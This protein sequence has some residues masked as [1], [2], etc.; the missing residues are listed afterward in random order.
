MS[1]T[2][3][4]YMREIAAQWS[5]LV[6]WL[7][8]RT[9]KLGE[10]G[11]FDGLQVQLDGDIG[12]HGFTIKETH[13]ENST[14]LE[15]A[16]KRA[17]A[18]DWSAGASVATGEQAQLDISFSASDAI[19]LHIHEGVEHR[20]SNLG[21][22]KRLIRELDGRAAWPKRQAVIVSVVKAASATVLIS[23]AK[24]A[25]MHCE[26][27]AG[28]ALGNLANPRLEL[29]STAERSMHT[30]ILAVG[31]LTPMYQAL[32]MRRDWKGARSLESALRGSETMD[33]SD[34]LREAIDEDFALCAVADDGPLDLNA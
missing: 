20:V 4:R 11:R 26:G 32:V 12:E 18:L 17:V 23:S 2:S 29:R 28:Q 8:S 27:K 5:Y 16:T 24:G 33:A 22:L 25:A 3:V 30:A 1:S 15:Y 14:S 31:E 21:E 9:V 10:T 19:V 7:P 34:P 6:T 13:D